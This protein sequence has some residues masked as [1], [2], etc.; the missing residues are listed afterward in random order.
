MAA[1]PAKEDGAEEGD[2]AAAVKIEQGARNGVKEREGKIASGPGR[3]GERDGGG[4]GGK[5][6]KKGKR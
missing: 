2:G 5:K 3:A 4:G 6:K 1:L